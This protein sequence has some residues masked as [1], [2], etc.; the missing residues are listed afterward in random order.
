QVVV[1]ADRLAP[2]S[3]QFSTTYS[4]SSEDI[5]RTGARSLDEALTLVPGLNVRNGGD[6]TPRIDVRGQR[7]RQIKLLVNGVPY[8]GT[9]DGQFD[10]T[11][12]PTTAISEIQVLTGASSLLYGDGGTAGVINVITKKGRGAPNGTVSG[13]IGE[14]G[15]RRAIASVGGGSENGDV[16]FSYSRHERDAFSMSNNFDE[17]SVQR[18]GDRVNSDYERNNFYI[19]GG[20]RL[21]PDWKIGLTLGYTDAERGAPPSVIDSGA[22]VFAQRPRYERTENINGLN[23]QLATEY[24]LSESTNIRLWIYTNQLEQ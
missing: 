11:L 1:R 9:S 3:D 16:Y 5:E 6:G 21:T 23:L 14:D 22:D 18:R 2:D 12:I 15:A 8:N 20:Y 4:V 13:E 10:P 24:R 7:T 19:N 17:T